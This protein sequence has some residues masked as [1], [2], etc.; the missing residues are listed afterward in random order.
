MRY[1]VPS[2]SL[3]LAPLGLL[4]VSLGLGLRAPADEEGWPQWR[5]GPLATGIS[6]ETGWSAE[7]AEKPLWELNVGLGY[8]T[9]SIQDG[10]LYTMGHDAEFQED[11]IFC[12]DPVT[13]DEIW[14]LPFPSKTWKMAHTGGTLSTPSA[15]GEVVFASNREGRL[16][17]LEAE[18]SDVRWEKQ[19]KEE[20]DLTYPRWMFGASPYVLEDMVVMNV[21]RVLAF[22]KKGELLWETERNYGDAYANPIAFDHVGVSCLAVFDSN[23]LAVLDR[24]TGRELAF[25]EWK[26]RN[27]VNAAT[28]VLVEGNL[29]VSSGM[30]MGCGMLEFT[31]SEIKVVWKSRVM[32]NSMS[33]CVLW[34]DHLYGLDEGALKCIDAAGEEKWSYPDLGMGC[35]VIAGGRILAMSARGELVV[36][37]ASPEGYQEL[38]R[39]K[40]LD[41]G[42]YWTTPVL[43]DGLIYC[44]NSNGDLVCLDHRAEGR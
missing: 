16:F 36:A 25:R 27:M 13:G 23:G 5:G 9:V 44:R 7:G 17:C 32:R 24:E 6:T 33:G 39:K 30:N 10:R 43:L 20:H 28:P 42:K 34:E 31:G 35:C 1:P 2:R 8:S 18:T 37:E 29:F 11:A 40:V 19:L 38:S 4:A 21:G 41:G 15:D 12:L 22:D 26:T 14:V 3:S